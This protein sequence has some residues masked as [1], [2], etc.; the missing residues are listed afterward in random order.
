MN[1][2]KNQM[3]VLGF[4]IDTSYQFSNEELQLIHKIV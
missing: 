4:L 1:I 2:P 3:L